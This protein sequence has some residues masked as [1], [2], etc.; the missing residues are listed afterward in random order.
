MRFGEP[1]LETIKFGDTYALIMVI[2]KNHSAPADKI[3]HEATLVVCEYERTPPYFLKNRYTEETAHKI[4]NQYKLKQA[5]IK[6]LI[7]RI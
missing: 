7:E 4:Y 6:K 5:N 1:I 3:M 2:G